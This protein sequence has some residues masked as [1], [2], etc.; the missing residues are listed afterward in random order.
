MTDADQREWLNIETAPRDGTEIDLWIEGQVG[1]TGDSMGR[2]ATN[3]HYSPVND[4]WIDSSGE[5]VTGLYFYDDE[6]ERCFD[7]TN[8]S[9]KAARATHWMPCP[10]PPRRK[11]R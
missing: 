3:C 9:A 10:E 11:R 1:R 7:P 6:G 2:R 8:K 4:T 5:W